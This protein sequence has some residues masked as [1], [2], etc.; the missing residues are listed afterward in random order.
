MKKIYYTRDEACRAAQEFAAQI[1][2]AGIKNATIDSSANDIEEDSNFTEIVGAWNG[3]VEAFAVEAS[4]EILAKFGFW[5]E[6]EAKRTIKFDG[7]QI[8]IYIT[9]DEIV[10]NFNT[11][12]GWA[13]YPRE[14]F[15]LA[16]ALV[17]QYFLD[18]ED[19]DP[20][21]RKRVAKIAEEVA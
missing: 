5:T 11:G 21:E 10:L 3:E 15:N 2:G 9:D 18:C 1:S 14:S 17:D 7:A 6:G 19:V 13:R 8:H 4:G 16:E 12:N 20:E